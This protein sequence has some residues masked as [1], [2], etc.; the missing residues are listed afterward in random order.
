MNEEFDSQEV[1]DLIADALASHGPNALLPSLDMPLAFN[2]GRLLEVLSIKL[3]KYL[4]QPDIQMVL[5]DLRTELYSNINRD[6]LKMIHSVIKNCKKCPNLEI[7]P[8]QPFWNLADPDVVLVMET[9]SMS[10]AVM[11]Y[12]VSILISAGF[13]SKRLA[14][15]FVNRCKANNRKHDVAEIKNCTSFLH[16]ELQLM[17]P[18]LII[19]LG[20][21]ATSTILGADITLGKE[22]GNICWLGPW[23]IMPTYSPAHVLKVENLQDDLALDLKNA[24]KFTYGERA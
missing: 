4:V 21:L 9:P 6:N 1:L 17:Q 8:Q 3:Q 11:D 24:H 23:A 13:S 22:R 20:L 12:L 5:D 10:K 15:T 18:K 19:P 16:A 14:L 2:E 7:N